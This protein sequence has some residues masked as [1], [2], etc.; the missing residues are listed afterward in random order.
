M[1][2]RIQ[3]IYLLIASIFIAL[4]FFFPLAELFTLK[5]Q[6]YNFD[7]DGIRILNYKN[8]KLIYS[9]FSLIVL[10]SIILLILLVSIFLY[11]KRILQMRLCIY[12]ILLMFGLI[13]L[14]YYYTNNFSEQLSANIHY[15]FPTTFPF[16]S[17]ILVYLAFRAIKKD[18]NLIR[19][20]D[21]I[22]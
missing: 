14:I 15:S 16:I 1:I 8:T 7:F 2:Q 11:K 3:T 5:S 20:L 4:M 6:I 12:N 10:L 13:G 18:E 17:I 19:S 9:T 22:R 21:R